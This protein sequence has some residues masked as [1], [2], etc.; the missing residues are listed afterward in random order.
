MSYEAIAAALNHSQASTSARLVLVTIA[1][2]E[3]ERGAWPSQE[4]LAKLTGLNPRTIRRAIH[5]LKELNELDVISDD[6]QGFGSRKTNRYFLILDCP[7]DC[8]RSLNHKKVT[9]EIVSLTAI[10]RKQ[11]RTETTAIQDTGDRN[12][13]QKRQQ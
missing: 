1:H 2:F 8:D 13:G 10:R 3:G 5:E 11:Y 7:D 12:R 4:T 9:A 6:G